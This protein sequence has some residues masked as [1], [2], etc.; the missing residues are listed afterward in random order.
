[1]LQIGKWKI[2][3]AALVVLCG[4][5]YALPNALSPEQLSALRA[6]GL[7]PT[8]TVNLGLDLRG[9]SHLLLEVDTRVVVSERVESMIDAARSELRAESVGYLDLAAAGQGISFRL[10]D[11]EKDRDAAYK[12]AR[13]LDSR[14]EVDIDGNG[15]VRVTLG[16]Q[17]LREIDAQAIG[18]SI[19]IVR[20][21]ID[22]SGTKEPVI[23]R[24]G[25]RRIVVELPGVD[26][27]EHVK[28][29]IGTT[30]KMS[31]HL[32]AESG[33]PGAAQMPMRDNPAVV[34]P[35]NR[36]VIISGDMLS[37]SQPSFDRE[38]P[39]VQFRFNAI[40]ARK[41]CD[42]TRDNVGKPFAIAL[43]GAI[44]SAP[45][46]NEAICGGSGIIRGN[47]TVKEA[48]DLSLLL[49]AGALP[50]PLKVVEERSVGPTLGADS[51]EAGKTACIMALVF[52]TL[53]AC[54]VYGLFGVFASVALMVNMTLIIAA[55]SIMQA[56]LT[57]PGIAG[58]V[59]TIGLAV[60][61]NV[62]VYERIKEELRAGR[63]IFSALDIG[64]SRAKTT[65]F[66]SNMSALIAALI[67]F[68]FGTGPI[69][70]FA[71]TMCIGVATSY[72][73]AMTLT[74]I[75][76]VSWTRWKKPKQISA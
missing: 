14:A 74:R 71:V 75:M 37:D 11:A 43:D 23:H 21:R 28:R 67:L 54:T 3:F 20:R 17:A 8:R 61:A 42:T 25:D 6:S 2:L 32:L 19:E 10:R 76:V 26:D 9:G 59:L 50:A 38:T 56:T 30:A 15:T 49:R 5:M 36:R 70:G 69:K 18:Q 39:V 52:V 24:Q 46:I 4:V 41:F 53:M 58:I 7:L 34:L 48:A 66:D 13:N 57:L 33:A 29:L 44:I 16:E 65:I 73:C 51:V 72:F 64:Y 1:M 22:E 62:L 35:V 40:G 45:V 47:F 63:S 12:I 55:M 60:D 27:P 31:F 68:S